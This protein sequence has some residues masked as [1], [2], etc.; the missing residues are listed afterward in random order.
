MSQKIEKKIEKIGQEAIE[1]IKAALAGV[2]Q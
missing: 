2:A 1:K